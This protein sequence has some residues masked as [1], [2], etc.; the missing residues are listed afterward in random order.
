MSKKVI[1]VHG[2]YNPFSSDRSTDR[3]ANDLRDDGYDVEEITWSYSDPTS[4]LRVQHRIMF[5]DSDTVVI[6]HSFGGVITQ[7]TP[8]RAKTIEVNTIFGNE[9]KGRD[10]WLSILDPFGTTGQGGHEISDDVYLKIVA[11]IEEI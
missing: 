4:I 1:V 6:G 11:K 8:T 5:A 10:D 3:L 2:L 9:V 7:G